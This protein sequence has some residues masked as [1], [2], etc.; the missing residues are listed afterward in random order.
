MKDKVLKYFAA[1][2][3]YGGFVSYFDRVFPSREFGRIYVLKGGPG[4]GKSSFMRSVSKKLLVSGATV[5]EI[6][7]SS[8]PN[9]LDGIIAT[10]GENRIA[11]LDGT[12]PH[13]RD[14][15]TPGVTDE[16]INLGEFWDV[17]WLAA[18]RDEVLKTN[19]IKGEAYATAYSYLSIAGKA[20]EK[21][22]DILRGSFDFSAARAW[23][24]KLIKECCLERNAPIKTA[25]F[26]SFGKYGKYDLE[27]PTYLTKKQISIGGYEECAYFLLDI[28]TQ[29]IKEKNAGAIVSYSPLDPTHTN[30]LIL[31]GELCVTTHDG[32]ETIDA[33]E[34]IKNGFTLDKERI[35]KA[36]EIHGDALTE[37]ARWFMIASDLHF[38][39]EEIYSRA[40][41]FEKIDMLTE[42]KHDEMEKILG[43]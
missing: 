43:L 16:I 32:V 37:A 9:S 34:F 12:A 25:L 21:I 35:K 13:E 38:R 8:D 5:E 1:S 20:E 26:S 14:A 42:K 19:H 39:L 33:N 29:I 10:N 4:T 22:K 40:M 24:N 3:S 11:V 6:Y 27:I 23:V 28:L 18:K 7:C 30:T 41:D 31:G 17:R 15:I 36:N 2:N